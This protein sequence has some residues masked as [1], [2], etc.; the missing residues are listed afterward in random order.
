MDGCT[1]R[2]LGPTTPRGNRGADPVGG[3]GFVVNRACAAYLR[4]DS[5][6]R[7]MSPAT[8]PTRP[9]LSHPRSRPTTARSPHDDNASPLIKDTAGPNQPPTA[10]RNCNAVESALA[11]VPFPAVALCLEP[12]RRAGALANTGWLRITAHCF[13]CPNQ[14]QQIF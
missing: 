4:G 2:R 13:F 7:S 11:E 3:G 1:D 9:N 12:T 5:R 10:V 6:N 14:R 8:T